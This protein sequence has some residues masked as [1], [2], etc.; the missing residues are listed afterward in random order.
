MEFLARKGDKPEKG[1]VDVEM[2]G[3]LPL[4]YYFT[5]QSHLLCVWG[6]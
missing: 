3:G 1:V 6:K 2:G 5:V 4:F